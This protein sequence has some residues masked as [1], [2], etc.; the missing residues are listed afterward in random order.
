[1]PDTEKLVTLTRLK[2]LL[3]AYGANPDFWPEEER[4]AASALI[5]TSTEARM[6]VEE[7]AA[8]D[9]LLDQIP[10]PQVSAALTSRVRSMALPV[11]EASTGGLFTRLAAYFAPQTPRGWQGAVAMAGVIGMAMGIG[12]TSLALDRTAPVPQIMADA[13]PLATTPIL[14]V[15]DEPET[16]TASLAPNLNTY[17]LTGEDLSDSADELTGEFTTDLTGDFADN[18][19][20][21]SE[22]DT[23]S[24]TSEFTIASVPL[25]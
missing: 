18:S 17:S 19:E 24:D 5:E 1:M 14:T 15:Q 12:L 3:D 2:S 10:E 20:D 6:L 8:L 13:T 21:N 4:A 25:Y 7:A 22:S 11:A 16:N 9:A 23:Q